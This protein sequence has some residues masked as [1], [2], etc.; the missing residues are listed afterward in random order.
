[1]NISTTLL[2][3]LSNRLLPRDPVWALLYMNEYLPKNDPIRL[4]FSMKA[5]K[6]GE[7]SNTKGSA[8]ALAVQ[9]A[10]LKE[11]PPG[12]ARQLSGINRPAG[13]GVRTAPED[14]RPNLRRCTRPFRRRPALRQRTNTAFPLN[15]VPLPS[16][17]HKRTG[18]LHS[19]AKQL[20]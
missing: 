5:A 11:L 13:N 3:H 7:S 1:M 17:D 8:L 6:I 19:C 9:G 2:K 18:L 15:A 10:R 16:V 12:L 4:A 14:L 20:S